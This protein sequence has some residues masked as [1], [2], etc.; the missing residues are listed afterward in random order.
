VICDPFDSLI[1]VNRRTQR[2]TTNADEVLVAKPGGTRALE[3]PRHRWQAI[4]L[5]FGKI[6]LE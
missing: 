1:S 3:R 6:G 2:L 5:D 4:K